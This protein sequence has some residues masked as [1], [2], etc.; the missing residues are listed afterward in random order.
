[1]N[2]NNLWPYIT[3]GFIFVVCLAVINRETEKREKEKLEEETKE[4]E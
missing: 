2:Q 1:M 4:L 3:I